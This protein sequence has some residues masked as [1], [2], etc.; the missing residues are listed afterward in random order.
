MNA[1][2]SPIPGK[3]DFYTLCKLCNVNNDMLQAL[4]DQSGVPRSVVDMMFLGTPVKRTEAAS[5]LA[6]FSQMVGHVRN[7]ENTSIPLT[8][9]VQ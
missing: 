8:E 9:E 7:L 3:P 1:Q 2:N 4:S 5:V 6:A